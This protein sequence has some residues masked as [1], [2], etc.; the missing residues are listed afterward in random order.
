MDNFIS[1]LQTQWPQILELI[2]GLLIAL[3]AIAKWTKTPEDDKW[4]ATILGWMNLLPVSAK[5]KLGESKKA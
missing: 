4:V 3:T 2:G 1:F 5:E